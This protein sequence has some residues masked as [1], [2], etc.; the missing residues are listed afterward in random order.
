MDSNENKKMTK[1][2]ANY[3]GKIKK[4]KI[5]LI[6]NILINKTEKDTPTKIFFHPF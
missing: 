2:I 3:S 6:C 5:S 4:E 1:N